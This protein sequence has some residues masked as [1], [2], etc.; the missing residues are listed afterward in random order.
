MAEIDINKATLD[1]E[2]VVLSTPVTPTVDIPFITRDYVGQSWS[3]IMAVNFIM[4]HE[5]DLRDNDVLADVITEGLS[6]AV[7]SVTRDELEG[8]YGESVSRREEISLDPVEPDV[9]RNQRDP[10]LMK[11][12]V[13]EALVGMGIEQEL[14]E[15]VTSADPD[16]RVVVVSDEGVQEQR[17]SAS[18]SEVESVAEDIAKKL[19]L[20]YVPTDTD[21]KNLVVPEVFV[22]DSTDDYIKKVVK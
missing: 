13:L 5:N 2:D 17:D 3:S 8:L 9:Y 10:K 19:G 16:D 7:D 11:S 22:T 20:E 21:K 14:G 15:D 1:P 4:E 18:P 12:F 6:G